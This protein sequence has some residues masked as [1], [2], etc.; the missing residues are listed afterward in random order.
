M[1]ALIRPT[2][3]RCCLIAAKRRAVSRVTG[4]TPIAAVGPDGSFAVSAS[5][6]ERLVALWDLKRGREWKTL[7]SADLTSETYRIAWT[8]SSRPHVR[9]G[10]TRGR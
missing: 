7:T 4:M 9:L 10:S 3:T 8:V 1:S 5:A 2:D 6:N